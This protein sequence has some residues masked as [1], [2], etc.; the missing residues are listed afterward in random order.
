M[1]LT[2]LLGSEAGKT[3]A[4]PSAEKN[5]R[6]KI[7]NAYQRSCIN[8]RDFLASHEIESK[9][10][11]LE[12]GFRFDLEFCPFCKNEGSALF[13]DT[14]GNCS[15]FH[16]FHNSC[17]EKNLREFILFYEPEQY[18]APDT[19]RP[20]DLTDAGNAQSFL[21]HH[22]GEDLLWCDALGWLRWTGQYW[23]RDDQSGLAAAIQFSDDMLSEA[24]TIA[25]AA[26][27][28][29]DILEGDASASEQAIDAAK[30]R[31]A[32]AMAYLA[33]AE[34]TRSKSRLEAIAALSIPALARPVEAFDADPFCLCTPMG[35]YDLRTGE[36]HPA[37]K[38]SLCTR[39]TAVSPSTD[40]TEM[41]K[42]FIQKLTCE[43]A[44]LGQYL[45]YVAGMSLIG[46]VFREGMILG[47][48]SGSNGKSSF[49]NALQYALGEYGG[50]IDVKALTTQKGNNIGPAKATLRGKRLVIAAESDEN[51]RLS[52]SVIKQVTSRD[53][54]V[55]EEKF[56]APM[57]F[58]PSHTLIMFT[59]FLPRIGSTDEGTWRRVA[60]VPFKAS[61]KGAGDDKTFAER[62]QSEAGGAALV[63]AIAG[64]VEFV[65]NGF[66]LPECAAVNEATQ[67]YREE[68]DW[69][70]RF[71]E[72]TITTG[73]GFT[74]GARVLYSQYKSWADDIG[75][76]FIRS[77]QQFRREMVS[78]GFQSEHRRNGT[79]W[80]GIKLAGLLDER[81]WNSSNDGPVQPEDL[82]TPVEFV[83]YLQDLTNN[84]KSVPGHSLGYQLKDSKV[85]HC[86]GEFLRWC[87][88]NTNTPDPAVAVPYK[89]FRD[90][91]VRESGTTISKSDGDEYFRFDGGYT[92]VETDTPW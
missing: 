91:M 54:V 85:K 45:Q 83:S 65:R 75:E 19:L 40:N 21:S 49:F 27:A 32:S 1:K 64:A 80:L 14:S 2:D 3:P 67:E 82:T 90:L 10:V 73:P 25:S 35:E 16:C 72:E 68:S 39:I 52:L 29:V 17:K 78:K 79:V 76:T 23:K 53:D 28:E 70:S 57:K 87:E 33:H 11:K 47:Y 50:S 81:N 37:R 4:S 13:A 26:K 31:L 71:L 44:D 20:D 61:F 66:E 86:W 34:H 69:L 77:E 84:I 24:R 56:K 62:L 7:K 88:S 60:V 6:K 42:N 74:I 5:R 36:A 92:Q 22:Y 46:K 51:D 15:G 38:E 55:G 12:E 9:E 43:D 89:L 30:Q 48:G 41:W 59:N 18:T 8:A 58:K 63:W